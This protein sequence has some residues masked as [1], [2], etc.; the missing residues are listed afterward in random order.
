MEEHKRWL[1]KA[2]VLPECIVEIA[3]VSCVY[4]RTESAWKSFQ[5]SSI[6]SKLNCSIS[7]RRR[8]FSE[9]SV[10]QHRISLSSS[11]RRWTAIASTQFSTSPIYLARAAKMVSSHF[12]IFS[13]SISDSRWRR[14]KLLSCKERS[15]FEVRRRLRQRRGH[16][17]HMAISNLSA[18]PASV[19]SGNTAR[20]PTNLREYFNSRRL[21]NQEFESMKVRM[22]A[23]YTRA[24]FTRGAMNLVIALGTPGRSARKRHINYR[25]AVGDMASPTAI[26][27]DTLQRR[28]MRKT[29]YSIVYV[30]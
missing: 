20:T 7:L 11:Q 12:N 21:R 22:G 27:P 26:R 5:F 25:F 14:S 1:K 6:S 8:S 15:W 28:S 13:I 16:R 3:S 9:L 18:K 24:G 17:F 4:K 30:A 23:G 2:I 10:H 19:P 29:W